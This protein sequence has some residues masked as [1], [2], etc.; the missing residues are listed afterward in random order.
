MEEAVPPRNGFPA[1]RAG[2]RDGTW[3][4]ARTYGCN[5]MP[6]PCRQRYFFISRKETRTDMR[7][8]KKLAGIALAMAMCL[9]LAVPAFA[10]ESD[11]YEVYQIFI[12]NYGRGDDG[13]EY[14]GDLMPGASYRNGDASMTVEDV[15]D[16]LTAKDAELT[17]P[18]LARYIA[19]KYVDLS[20][21]YTAA[22]VEARDGEVHVSGL[23]AG[24]YMVR[25]TGVAG[26]GKVGMTFVTQVTASTLTFV[27]KDT[28]NVP[29]FDKSITG[30]EDGKG[31]AK[32]SVSAVGDTVSFAVTVTLP[33]NVK[34]YDKY[35]VGV[36]DKMD[37][38]LSLQGIDDAGY[39]ITVT[40]NGSETV[41][42][43]FYKNAV[44]NA[45]DT[46]ITV[47]AWLDT[48]AVNPGDVY[49]VSYKATVNEHANLGKDPNTNTAVLAYSNNPADASKPWSGP[50]TPP[51]GPDDP[52]EVKGLEGQTRT[53]VTGVTVTYFKGEDRADMGKR[54]P[55][56]RF[57]L[58]G[59]GL[60]HVVEVVT[61]FA[62]DPDG[63]YWLLNNGTYTTAAPTADT[64]NQYVD[65]MGGQKYA[66][67]TTVNADASDGAVTAYTD[68]NGQVV[69]G[70]LGVGTYTLVQET[71]V[72][73]LKTAAPVEFKISFNHE[74]G[75]LFSSDNPG[76]R[77]GGGSEAYPEAEWFY[78][79]IS[80]ELGLLLPETGGMGTYALY[81]AGIAMIAAAG[82]LLFLKGRKK[83][84]E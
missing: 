4:R 70:G 67:V 64:A 1:A 58:S 81:A 62:A 36:T 39:G 21:P 11:T 49:V 60:N 65:G 18:E 10:A 6:A 14:L 15:V 72:G 28:D 32:D 30:V 53:Y 71:S 55:G 77:E 52:G 73:G 25:Q 56:A 50:D 38:G 9:A 12:G 63:D 74:D 66:P 83:T 79:D 13:G 2:G 17:E 82:S 61:G 3:R 48:A 26:T 8:L 20:K 7:N 22:K 37:K 34:A 59:G 16:D 45:E 44:K 35:Y 31:D 51:D 68:G 57:V 47:A 75:S 43:E 23:V 80:G 41:T 29:G 5:G 27:P 54:L 84:G 24:Y 19:D 46:E 78:I 40:R 42:G 76:V 33:A 69:I